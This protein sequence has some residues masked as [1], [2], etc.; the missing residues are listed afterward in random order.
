MSNYVVTNIRLPEE[1]YLRLKEEALKKRKSL[2]AVIRE[3]INGKKPT[4]N[5]AKMLLELN[6]DWFTEKDYREY[7]KNR[8]QMEK[9][10]KGL[11]NEQKGSS[12]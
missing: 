8:S 9:R 12:R 6:T 11:W 4:K 2:A 1:D 5:F 10:I 3:K 7:K